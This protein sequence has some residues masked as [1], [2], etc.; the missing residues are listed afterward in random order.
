[1]AHS[2]RTLHVYTDKYSEDEVHACCSVETSG[3]EGVLCLPPRW[4]PLAT[5]NVSHKEGNVLSESR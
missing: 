1:M 3:K 2:Y 5:F 4:L